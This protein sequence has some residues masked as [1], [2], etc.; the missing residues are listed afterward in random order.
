[1]WISEAERSYHAQ[2]EC[3]WKSAKSEVK[4][5]RKQKKA[6]KKTDKRSRYKVIEALNE[7][8][9][10]FRLSDHKEVKIHI[11]QVMANRIFLRDEDRRKKL[12]AS[13][14]EKKNRYYSLYGF[15]AVCRKKANVRHHI[16]QLKN[17]GGNHGRNLIRLCNMCHE[18][19]HPWMTKI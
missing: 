12:R 15:C 17:G 10:A 5:V 8:W 6:K 9:K 19:I 7:F 13:F 11:L 18:S 2:Q 1:M 3:R 16:V 4:F 14:N